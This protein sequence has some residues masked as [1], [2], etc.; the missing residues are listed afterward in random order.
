VIFFAPGK[1]KEDVRCDA[2]DLTAEKLP[3]TLCPGCPADPRFGVMGDHGNQGLIPYT[4]A[5]CA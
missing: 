5:S 3:P 2:M 4:L 1:K